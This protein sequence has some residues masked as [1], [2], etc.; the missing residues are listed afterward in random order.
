MNIELRHLQYFIIVAEE[1]NFRRAAAR[2]NIA[3]P[4]LTRQIRQLEEELGVELFYRTTRQTNLTQAGQVSL[5]EDHRALALVQEGV[6]M[7]RLASR[8]EVGRLV[9][10]FEGSSA[11][12]IVPKSVKA[13]RDRYPPLVLYLSHRPFSN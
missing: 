6:A 7:A 3:Q 4:P 5:L 1:L 13:F 2:L 9:V 10:G 12:D 8:G 11:Y